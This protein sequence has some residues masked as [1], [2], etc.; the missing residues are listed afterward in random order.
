LIKNVNLPQYQT[1]YYRLKIV[2]KDGKSTVSKIVSVAFGK[3]LAVRVFPNP[4]RDELTI[5][6]PTAVKT[7][8]IELVDVLGRSV[9]RQ[10]TEG[11]HLLKINTTNWQSGI[12]VLKISDGTSVFQQKIVKQ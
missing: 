11:V 4:I 8:T 9:F 12:Y 10:N 3:N 7:R 2:D 1:Q 5:E 6:W